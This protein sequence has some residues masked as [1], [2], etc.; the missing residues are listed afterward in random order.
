MHIW[1]CLH[2]ISS[3]FLNLFHR[4][5]HW[6][7]RWYF[8]YGLL[9][10]HIFSECSDLFL[11][12]FII[13][14]IVFCEIEWTC[15]QLH[16]NITD[17]SFIPNMVLRWT[18]FLRRHIKAFRR[19]WWEHVLSCFNLLQRYLTRSLVY[20]EWHNILVIYFHRVAFIFDVLMF[21]PLK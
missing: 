12:S 6:P 16:L 15:S 4:L 9:L 1:L 13:K 2:R 14:I 7:K 21:R 17:I 19:Q 11:H 3:L 5:G 8:A 20:F 10:F 18:R